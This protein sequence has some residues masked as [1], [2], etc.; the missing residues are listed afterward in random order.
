MQSAVWVMTNNRRVEGIFHQNRD[1]IQ[2]LMDYVSGITNQFTPWYSIEYYNNEAEL[3]S[4][5]AQSIYGR[6]NARLQ[7]KTK[8]KVVVF[9]MLNNAHLRKEII[10]Q[11]EGSTHPINVD[12]SQLPKGRY[13][14]GFYV[15]GAGRMDEKVFSI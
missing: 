5:S 7:A 2:S 14:I 12:V 4:D 13:H 9:D 3:V 15:V 6:F 8:V 10:V 11:E 1:S